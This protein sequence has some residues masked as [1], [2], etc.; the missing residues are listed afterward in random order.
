M[1]ARQRAALRI[2]AVELNGTSTG[3]HAQRRLHGET[4]PVVLAQILRNALREVET[5]DTVSDEDRRVLTLAAL[6]AT[7]S[8]LAG[9]VGGDRTEA[10]AQ[11]TL[12]A[13]AGVALGLPLRD[14]GDAAGMS[15][16]A[17]R[18]RIQGPSP[19]PA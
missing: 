9:L 14:L 10:S 18:K 15:H 2:A 11:L 17:I 16:T 5:L 8:W 19:L 6:E 3:R 13:R 4:P 7:G 1:S 12:L